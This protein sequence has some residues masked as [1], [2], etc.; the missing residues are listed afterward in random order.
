MVK[1][2]EEASS[3]LDIQMAN[4]YIKN[5]Q[6]EPLDKW[7]LKSQWDTTTYLTGWQNENKETVTTVN[8]DKDDEKLDLSY[9][10]GGKMK[11]DNHSEIHFGSLLK[12]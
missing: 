7:K 1:S 3:K 10:S 5:T 6:H 9:I 12:N 4:K 2:R 11:W 8:A